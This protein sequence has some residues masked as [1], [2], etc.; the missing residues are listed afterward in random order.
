M[1]ARY[2]QEWSPCP[3]CGVWT[4]PI[5]APDCACDE[6]GAEAAREARE[7]AEEDEAVRRAEERESWR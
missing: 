4:H 7:A 6:I 2:A 5:E 1:S 3:D